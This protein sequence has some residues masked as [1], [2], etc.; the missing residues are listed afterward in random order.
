MTT[1][2]DLSESVEMYLKTIYR[3][4][5]RKKAAKA[6]DIAKMMNVSS[7]SV[8]GAL[9]HL[10]DRNFINYEPYDV[11]TLTDEGINIAEDILRKH[12]AIK[13]FFIEIL[14][15]EETEADDCACRIEHVIYPSIYKRLVEFVKWLEHTPCC[16]PQ[17][18]HQFKDHLKKVNLEEVEQN[19]ETQSVS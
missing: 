16:G 2:H 7:S 11:I 17:V 8:T 18:L 14:D 19:K 9:H 12:T 13:K 4:V 10:A 6:K 5:E 1:D 15:A 3:I